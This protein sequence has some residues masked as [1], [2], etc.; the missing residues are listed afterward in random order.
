MSDPM[1]IAQRDPDTPCLL[2]ESE[3]LVTTSGRKYH[4]SYYDAGDYPGG[5]LLGCSWP[6]GVTYQPPRPYSNQTCDAY[7]NPE[8]CDVCGSKSCN[9]YS[10]CSGPQKEPD[11]F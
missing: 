2:R 11:Y 1:C 3:H 10:K 5:G 9:N 7:G 8:G 4:S 6:D